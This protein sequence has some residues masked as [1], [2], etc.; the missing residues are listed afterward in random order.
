MGIVSEH[1]TEIFLF[2][3]FENNFPPPRLQQAK[4]CARACGSVVRAQIGIGV[5]TE[6]TCLGSR[7]S[8][9]HL[10]TRINKFLWH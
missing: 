10:A 9:L 8:A 6:W 4:C 1:E 7:D 3:L 5:A 2:C